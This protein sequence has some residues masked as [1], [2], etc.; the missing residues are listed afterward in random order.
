MKIYLEIEEMKTIRD[1]LYVSRSGL[2]Q[3]ISKDGA[4]AKL[5]ESAEEL[6]CKNE[7]IISYF[8]EIIRKEEG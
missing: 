2:L 7:K 5:I 8:N 6:V 3:E 4:S 1:A